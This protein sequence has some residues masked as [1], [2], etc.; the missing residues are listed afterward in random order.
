MVTVIFFGVWG[1]VYGPRHL[2]KIQ[3]AA[4]MLTVLAVQPLARWRWPPAIERTGSYVLLFEVAGRCFR[5]DGCR[6]MV[7]RPRAWNQ[8]TALPQVGGFDTAS[9]GWQLPDNRKA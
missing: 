6:R 8:W 1:Q 3:G 2:G 4:Q 7:G 5:D 9:G